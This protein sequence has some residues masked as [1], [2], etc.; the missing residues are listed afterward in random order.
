MGGVLYHKG[1]PKRWFSIPLNP[2][3]LA[4]F[5]AEK[6]DPAFNTAWEAMALLV[7]LRLWLSGCPRTL[8]VRVKSDNVGAL[9][10][11]LNLTSQSS[12]MAII[13]RE[14]ALDIAGGNYQ[15]YELEHVAGV[16]NVVA[17]ALSRVWAPHHVDFPFLGDAV[18]DL[19]PNLD[20]NF[21]KVV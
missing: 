10:M 9:R 15:L 18:K 14:I 4:K 1:A 16:T 6:G 7:A 2:E 13:A 3:L 17:D 5:K 19:P 8:A 12:T 11:L 20:D 21:W